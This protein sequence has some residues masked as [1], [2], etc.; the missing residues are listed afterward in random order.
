VFSMIIYLSVIQ[1]DQTSV[2]GT[3][4]MYASRTVTA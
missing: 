1:S 4:L 2:M 3:M